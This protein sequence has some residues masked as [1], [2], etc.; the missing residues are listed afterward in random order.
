MHLFNR[1]FGWIAVILMQQILSP[2]VMLIL[3]FC[4]PAP[5]SQALADAP[6]EYQ[7]KAAFVYNFIAFTQ[8][9]IDGMSQTINL[10][11]YGKDY[12]GRE[13]DKLARRPIDKRTIEVIRTSNPTYLKNCQ[14]VFFSKSTND[15]AGILHNLH[16]RPVLTLADS[17]NAISEGIIINL[18]VMDEKIVFE[19]NLGIAR[20][21]GLDFSSKLLQLAVKVHQ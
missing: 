4:L 19:I 8:W 10:C 12:F 15:I 20:K 5:Y 11:V 9:P 14:V 18:D 16:D 17:A 2:R 3:G 13:I 7:V 21:S 1:L 6:I